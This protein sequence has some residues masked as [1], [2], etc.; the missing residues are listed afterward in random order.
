MGASVSSSVNGGVCVCDDN[1][2][3]GEGAGGRMTRHHSCK[4]SRA[5][6]GTHQMGSLPSSAV[7]ARQRLGST[8]EKLPASQKSGPDHNWECKLAGGHE[9]SAG[10]HITGWS[11]GVRCG[12]RR[13]LR[14]D[15]G[16]PG[17]LSPH[18]ESVPRAGTGLRD[19]ISAPARPLR[20]GSPET[21]RAF[22]RGWVFGRS[23]ER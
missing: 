14:G 12:A 21:A 16:E 13:W 2:Y 22:L 1:L 17:F 7:P 5:R 8:R 19:C 6:L 10:D 11:V 9:I 4:V 20:R 3:W 18:M 23:M 15:V